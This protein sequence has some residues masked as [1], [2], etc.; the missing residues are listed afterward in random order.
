MK[1]ERISGKEY[2][3]E[4]HSCNVFMSVVFSELNRHKVDDIHYLVFSDNKTRLGITL[5]ERN[6]GLFSPFSA[7][8]GGF[9]CNSDQRMEVYDEASVMLKS[10]GCGLGK[11][12]EIALPPT[13]YGESVVSK[14]LSSLSRAGYIKWFDLNCYFP[15]SSFLDYVGVIHRNARKNL[16]NGMKNDFIFKHIPSTDLEG[17]KAAYEVI[18]LNREEHGYNLRMSLGDVM[19]TINVVPADF[20]L[21][22]YNGVDV[23]SAMVYRL[24]PKIC[25]V[26]YWGNIG[27][28][29]NLRPMNVLAYR[30]F[31]YYSKLDIDIIDIGPSSIDGV[32]DYGLLE[33]KESIGC[34]VCSKYWLK[35]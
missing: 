25:Q 3:E 10:Y 32:P 17:V 13:C 16:M 5:G 28:Y 7:P 19:S 20:F 9:C 33:F 21:L 34:S 12:I 4:F 27:A 35:L 18:R 11:S 1:V 31:E 2:A 26:I 23:A 22:S 8:F 14:Q 24:A 29:S 30:L 15:T 6:D